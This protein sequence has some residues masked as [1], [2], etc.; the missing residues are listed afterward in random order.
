MGQAGGGSAAH[1]GSGGEA[2]TFYT[3]TLTTAGGHFVSTD[4]LEITVG[5]GGSREGTA[6]DGNGGGDG[7][8]GRV[9]ILGIV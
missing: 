5:A 6:R 8:S 9:R 2:G 1:G 4:H 7:G 3:T